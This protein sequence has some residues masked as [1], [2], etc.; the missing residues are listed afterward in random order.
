MIEDIQ[1]ATIIDT[2]TARL[3]QRMDNVEQAYKHIKVADSCLNCRNVSLHS[4]GKVRLVCK[5]H[6]CVVQSN[7]WCKHHKRSK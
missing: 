1:S 6:K 3:E 4:L 5:Q 2:V 7:E